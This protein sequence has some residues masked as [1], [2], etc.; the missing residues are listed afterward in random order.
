M[1]TGRWGEEILSA[2]AVYPFNGVCRDQQKLMWDIQEEMM[3]E[4]KPQQP[5][6]YIPQGIWDQEDI[7]LLLLSR[8]G[9]RWHGFIHEPLLVKDMG[10]NALNLS[11]KTSH[12]LT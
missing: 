7:T 10:T 8:G 4:K 12:V 1:S 9:N 2:A 6:N 3:N 5:C 11:Y